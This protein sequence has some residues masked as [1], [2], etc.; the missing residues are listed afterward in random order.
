MHEF[1]A[2]L[3]LCFVEHENVWLL[4]WYCYLFYSIC[5]HR[6]C[7]S[8]GVVASSFWCLTNGF[9]LHLV[10]S[11]WHIISVTVQYSVTLRHV[12]MQR[13]SKKNLIK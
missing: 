6:G 3:F 12:I 13:I 1:E 11:V 2:F 5:G 9:L 7:H 8:A 4:L 10:L